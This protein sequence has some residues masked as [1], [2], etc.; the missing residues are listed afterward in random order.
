M[1]SPYPIITH[2]IITYHPIRTRTVSMTG[3]CPM[4]PLSTNEQPVLVTSS[5]SCL[6]QHIHTVDIERFTTLEVLFQV[7]MS[8]NNMVLLVSY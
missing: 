2:P 6:T 8:N 1:S 3:D 4:A 5:P 7:L